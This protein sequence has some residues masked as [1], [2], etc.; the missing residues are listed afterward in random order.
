MTKEEIR[1]ASMASLEER[2]AQ[3]QMDHR[4]WMNNKSEQYREHL[5]IGAELCLRKTEFG[6]AAEYAIELQN[7]YGETLS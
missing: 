2:R 5:I 3:L 4:T 7:I 6:E 1:A